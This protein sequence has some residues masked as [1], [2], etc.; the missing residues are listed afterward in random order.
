MLNLEEQ[1]E[2]G[3]TTMNLE[4]QEELGRTRMN[5]QKK[6]FGMYSQVSESTGKTR[7]LWR[8][9]LVFLPRPEIYH[10]EDFYE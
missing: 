1:E 8:G 4:E 2:L 6:L 7:F 9:W 5:F 3:R 10:S